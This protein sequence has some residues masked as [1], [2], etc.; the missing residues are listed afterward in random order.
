MTKQQNIETYINTVIG[1]IVTT[2]ALAKSTGCTLPTVLK[3]IKNNPNRF[4]KEGKGTYRILAVS[5]VVTEATTQANN[6]PFQW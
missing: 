4:Q 1:A 2:S 3:Y 5:T 6:Q